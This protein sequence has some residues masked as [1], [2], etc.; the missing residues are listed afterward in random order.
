MFI[1]ID[2]ARLA[3]VILLVASAS[4]CG[5]TGNSSTRKA[6]LLR[7]RLSTAVEGFIKAEQSFGPSTNADELVANGHWLDRMA[8][9]Y[10]VVESVE[11][12]L[13]EHGGDPL[14]DLK[15]ELAG[16]FRKHFATL[17]SDMQYVDAM[18]QFEIAKI[19]LDI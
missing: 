2:R 16:R 10:S 5:Y 14:V 7:L 3:A 9:E 6:A 4:G 17:K 11:T 1:Q 15:E 12:Q 19:W 13:I 18:N 8:A